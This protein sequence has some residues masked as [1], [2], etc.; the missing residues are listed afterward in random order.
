M[1]MRRHK[2]IPPVPHVTNNNT[3]TVL[4]NQLPTEFLPERPPPSDAIYNV[5]EL[6]TQ[7][8]LF[9]YHHTTA[10]FP[11]KPTWLKAIK[12][13]QFA[14]W[15]GLMANAVIKH[16]LESDEMHKGHERKLYSSPQ[17]TKTTPTSNDDD[18]D[19]DAQP[20]HAPWLTT[21]QK[22]IFFKIYDLKVEAQLMMYT[23]QTGNFPKKSSAAISTS[24][25]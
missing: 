17:S 16:F 23:D 25:Y 11:T 10:R 13:K 4:C 14:Y 12:N 24:W 6:K 9:R 20:T 7:P 21:K 5:C 3:E 15:P 8:K 1:A 22:R 2:R 18:D 19:N